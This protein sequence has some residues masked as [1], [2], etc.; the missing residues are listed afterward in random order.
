[1]GFF[2]RAQVAPLNLA[3]GRQTLRAPLAFTLFHTSHSTHVSAR[4]SISFNTIYW[5]IMVKNG[6]FVCMALLCC[7]GLL[8]SSVNA[9]CTSS[10]LRVASTGTSSTFSRLIP[11]RRHSATPARRLCRNKKI[12]FLSLHRA[13]FN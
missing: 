9:Q 6:A 7:L 8:L 4:I 10:F 1:V 3:L 11:A 12:F 13:F 2:R 5:R